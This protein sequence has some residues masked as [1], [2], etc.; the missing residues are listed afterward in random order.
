MEG[1][2]RRL[3]QQ[4][5]D[6]AQDAM[7]T[8]TH[9]ATVAKN[10]FESKRLV[11]SLSS[12]S[13]PSAEKYLKNLYFFFVTHRFH[14]FAK[15]G[16]MSNDMEVSSADLKCAIGFVNLAMTL[17]RPSTRAG[18]FASTTAAQVQDRLLAAPIDL[19]SELP[20]TYEEHKTMSSFGSL[21]CVLDAWVVPIL[22]VYVT[23][24]RRRALG[25]AEF[26]TASALLFPANFDA[27]LAVFLKLF[28]GCP[29]QTQVRSWFAEVIGGLHACPV[30]GQHVPELVRA[31]AHESSVSVKHYHL[32]TKE[33]SERLVTKFT[34]ERFLQPAEQTALLILN[35]PTMPCFLLASNVGASLQLLQPEVADRPVVKRKRGHDGS[36]DGGVADR[37]AFVK[38]KRGYNRSGAPSD[39]T[40]T[41]ASGLEDEKQDTIQCRNRHRQKKSASLSCNVVCPVVSL[42]L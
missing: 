13:R 35:R 40:S 16:S 31:C 24:L 36:G 17:C 28:P 39:A 11:N 25:L 42:S 33:A 12:N 19:H 20:L 15:F 5:I 32:T 41:Q 9:K 23:K 38:R 27:C 26:Q 4:A 34:S 7:T 21:F 1:E 22:Y 14:F 10:L 37:P 29:T 6:C 3:A 2:T 30:W 8:W 18:V